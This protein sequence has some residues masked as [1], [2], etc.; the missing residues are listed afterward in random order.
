MDYTGSLAPEHVSER[1]SHVENNISAAP[2]VI[3]IKT[4]DSFRKFGL[5]SHVIFDNEKTG[6]MEVIH[7]KIRRL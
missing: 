1:L 7:N 6:A 2:N 3:D 4:T 5:I